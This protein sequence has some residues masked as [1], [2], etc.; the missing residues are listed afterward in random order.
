[1]SLLIEKFKIIDKYD[2]V[3]KKLAYI[4]FNK[5]QNKILYL[6]VAK[7]SVEMTFFKLILI[8]NYGPSVKTFTKIKIID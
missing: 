6:V 5:I 4:D 1:M 3:F 7:L 8:R 2:I